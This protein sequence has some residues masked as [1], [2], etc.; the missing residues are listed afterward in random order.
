MKKKIIVLFSTFFYLGFIPLG[1]GTF[2]TIG[3][4]PF[5]YFLISFLDQLSYLLVI[6]LVISLSIFISNEAVKIFNDK[7][8]NQVVIDEVVGFL[9]TM[10]FIP[11][12]I[13]N[14]VAGF[15]LFRFFDITKPYPLR[16]LEKL[17][18]GYGIVL[19]DVAAGLWANAV[20]QI[21]VRF[22]V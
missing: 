18:D 22:I 21:F 2:G 19:D 8:P 9:V 12:S 5:Y 16:N 20:L 13:T 10:I 7:D 17:K 11:F 1:P 6:L 4:I 3:A 14:I 15:I